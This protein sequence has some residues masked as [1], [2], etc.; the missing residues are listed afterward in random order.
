MMKF[1]TV[2]FCIYFFALVIANAQ[3]SKFHWA[4]NMGGTLKDEGNSLAIDSNGNVYITGWFQGKARFGEGI[5]T[6]H[7]ISSG[8]S[9]IFVAKL[10]SA[11]NLLWVKQMR[12]TL[13][14]GGYAIA[15]DESCN[16]YTAGFFKGTVD[17]NPDSEIYELTSDGDYDIFITKL[18]S[19]GNFIWA[20]RMGG[21]SIEQLSTLAVDLSGYVYVGGYFSDIADFDPSE[22]FFNLTAAGSDHSYDIFIAKLD[23]LGNFVWAKQM[24]GNSQDLLHSLT[25]DATGN[26]YATGS[27]IGISDF[28]PG[29]DTFILNSELSRDIFVTK[30]DSTGKLI[31]AKQMG[32]QLGILDIL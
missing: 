27:F 10:D 15:I 5:N 32:D 26:I 1:T 8:E 24:G 14:D 30:L 31:W 18:D 13:N 9:D 20:K 11:G 6:V 22:Q 2:L 16:V 19:S 29:I 17:F 21:G 25:L 7:L 3:L 28:D 23:L 4:K 12:G